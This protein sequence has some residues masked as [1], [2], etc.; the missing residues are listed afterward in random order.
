MTN[1]RILELLI[2][3][4]ECIARSDYCGRDCA[5]CELVQDEK[6]LLEM[7]DTLIWRYK[8]EVARWKDTDCRT[9]YTVN[10]YSQLP[11]NL[12]TKLNS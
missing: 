7:Y 4:R 12:L 2:A 10:D 5:S 9:F 3:E 6:E 8:F 11:P 1:Q